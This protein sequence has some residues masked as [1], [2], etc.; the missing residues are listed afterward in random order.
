MNDLE[1]QVNLPNQVNLL[2]ISNQDGCSAQQIFDSKYG[3]A[4]DDIIILPN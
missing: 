1:N 3:Y 4:Y 2:Q